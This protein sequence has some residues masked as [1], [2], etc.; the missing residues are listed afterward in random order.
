MESG[1]IF[2]CCG[3]R[4]LNQQSGPEEIRCFITH[5]SSVLAVCQKKPSKI[6]IPQP[7]DIKSNGALR[8]ISGTSSQ[9]LM[10]GSWQSIKID[11]PDFGG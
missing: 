9:K 4:I 11:Y 1:K 3:Y 10:A 6:I 7:S 5:Q 2:Q 8:K